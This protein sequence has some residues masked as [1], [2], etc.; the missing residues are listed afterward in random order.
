MSE[1][2]KRKTHEQRKRIVTAPF[3]LPLLKSGS[4]KPPRRRKFLRVSE[5]WSV[6]VPHPLAY[7]CSKNLL[8]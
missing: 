7:P 5:Q 4:S 2:C 1:F 8:G 6:S 3:G